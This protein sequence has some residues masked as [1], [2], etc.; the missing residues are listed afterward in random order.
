MGKNTQMFLLGLLFVISGAAGY[1][2]E[3]A[4]LGDENNN[5]VEEVQEIIQPEV[6]LSPVPVVEVVEAPKKVN[7][8]YAFTAIAST[9][10]G[11]IELKYVLYRDL[12]CT[13]EVAGNYDGKFIDVPAVESQTYY[14]KV[15]NIRKNIWSDAV[16][17]TGFAVPQEYK[18]PNPM[19]KAEVEAIIKD[20]SSASK[21]DINNRI[22]KVKIECQGLSSEDRGVSTISEVSNNLEMGIWSSAE[23]ISIGHDGAG[24]LNKLVIK[25][26]Y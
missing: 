15:W 14:L 25:V 2:I 17:V 10:S 6:G 13:E 9:E 22:A 4:L 1:F 3:G 20:Y 5:Q 18:L 21:D 26:T 7:G 11:D 19:T 12:E 23:V 24:R 16:T 8:N